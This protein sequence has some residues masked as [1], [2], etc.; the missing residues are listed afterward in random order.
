ME[1][2]GVENAVVW[3]VGGL[4]VRVQESGVQGCFVEHFG[5]RTWGAGITVQ[6]LVFRVS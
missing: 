2:W 4:R 6:G 1:V 3:G 5:L